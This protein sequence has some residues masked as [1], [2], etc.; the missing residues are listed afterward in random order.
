MG[1]DYVNLLALSFLPNTSN[2]T[3]WLEDDLGTILY[4]QHSGRRKARP[5]YTP[6]AR[7]ALLTYTPVYFDLTW[8]LMERI[9][10]QYLYHSKRYLIE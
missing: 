2:W 5:L 3:L 6:S 9:D 8:K 7:K 10:W 4:V 1:A